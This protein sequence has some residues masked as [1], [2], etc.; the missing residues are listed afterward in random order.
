M[1]MEAQKFGHASVY[2]EIQ[3]LENMENC[4]RRNGLE[5]KLNTD[6][7]DDLN[8]SETYH[9]AEKQMKKNVIFKSIFEENFALSLT[10][11]L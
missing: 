7:H 6:I 10:T 2:N 5:Y 11:L 9:D 8:H 1:S 4:E 3:A